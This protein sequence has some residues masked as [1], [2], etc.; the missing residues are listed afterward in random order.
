MDAI[1][2]QRER[3]EDLI[4]PAHSAARGHGRADQLRSHQ[5]AAASAAQPG[6][7]LVKS[8]AELGE[9]EHGLRDPGSRRSLRRV[10]DGIDPVRAVQDD[11]RSELMPPLARGIPDAAVAADGDVNGLLTPVG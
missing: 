1:G 7:C 3:S 8:E 4:T 11:A 9:V 10:A 2:D 6:E 5:P